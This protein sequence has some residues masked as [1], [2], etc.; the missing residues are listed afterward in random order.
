MRKLKD[1]D[2][3][4]L[5]WRG[6]GQQHKFGVHLEG[7]LD[8][9]STWLIML[10]DLLEPLLGGGGAGLRGTTSNTNMK[11]QEQNQ[12]EQDDRK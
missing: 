4:I 7:S 8:P 9:F 6:Q 5:P 10:L 1:K 3:G 12:T 2:V 11:E